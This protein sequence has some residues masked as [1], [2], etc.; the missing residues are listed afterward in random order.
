MA[1]KL[2]KFRH[3]NYKGIFHYDVIDNAFVVLSRYH[4]SKIEYIKEHG[5]IDITFNVEE[6]NYDVLSV[7]II[8]DPAYVKK[9]YDHF[10]QHENAY[11]TDGIEVVVSGRLNPEGD[12]QAE[13]L[14]T[15]CE[16]KY[17]AKLEKE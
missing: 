11:F 9:V 2:V 13:K 4:S 14:M 12:F 10:L 7:D 8:E 3:G 16:S 5:A 1:H 17:K 6:E 15:R